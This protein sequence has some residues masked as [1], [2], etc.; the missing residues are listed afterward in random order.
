MSVATTI[1]R[2]TQRTSP[3]RRPASYPDSTFHT[4]DA[5]GFSAEETRFVLAMDTYK[6]EKRRPFPTWR[7]VLAVVKSLGY[8]LPAA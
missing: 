5:G 7:E 4:E 8:R 6:R 3:S 2:A 1:P